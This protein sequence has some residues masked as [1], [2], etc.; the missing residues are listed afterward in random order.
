MGRLVRSETVTCQ[1]NGDRTYD[2]WVGICFLDGQDIVA[3]AVA[4]CF[5]L[6]CWRYSNGRYR[7]LETAAARSRIR[8]AGYC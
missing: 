8:R 6:D 2:R 5:A 4:N 1:L 7:D 3:S